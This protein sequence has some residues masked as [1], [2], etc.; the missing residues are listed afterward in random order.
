MLRGTNLPSVGAYNQTVVLE[1][2]RRAEQG[3]SRAEMAVLSGLSAQTVSNTVARLTDEGLIVEAGTQV[4][5]RGKPP[6]ML[7]LVPRSR[8]AVG[9][10]LD[11]AFVSYVLLDLAGSVVASAHRPTPSPENHDEVVAEMVGEIDALIASAGVERSNVLG[12]GL[13]SQG[14]IDAERGIVIGHPTMKGW[15]DVHLRN[16]IAEA[17]GLEVVFA[18]GVNAAAVAEQWIGDPGRRDFALVYLASG[19]GTG[20]VIDGRVVFGATGNA[21]DGGRIVVPDSGVPNAESQM[22][23]HLVTAEYLVRQAIDD[24]VL[25]TA[26]GEDVDAQFDRLLA[27]ATSGVRDALRIFHRAGRNIGAMIVTLVNVLDIS[28]VVFG[29]VYWDRIAP[30]VLSSIA[31][32]VQTSSLRGTHSD[33]KISTSAIG[34]E[35]PAVGAACLVLDTLLSPRAS[36]MLL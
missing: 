17:T 34:M 21:G 5:G 8:F 31:Y 32:V 30:H 23:G 7:R 3:V 14:P 27:A 33:I 20:L 10:N 12:I 9:V 29:G 6:T 13:A 1:L 11:A 22:V 15:H 24:G 16:S 35:V 2:I 19:I 18:S 4:Q 36:S 28:E 26:P 25:T